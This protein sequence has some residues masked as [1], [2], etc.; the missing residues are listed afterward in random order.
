MSSSITTIVV[1]LLVLSSRMLRIFKLRIWFVLKYFWA[2]EILC[3]CWNI[4]QYKCYNCVMHHYSTTTP[5]LFVVLL[6]H[7]SQMFLSNI[8]ADFHFVRSCE[9]VGGV[10]GHMW[11]DRRWDTMTVD[12]VSRG[13]SSPPAGLCQA[14]RT[15]TCRWGPG[16]T[17]SDRVNPPPGASGIL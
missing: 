10:R 17:G 12:G 15:K 3:C 5:V 11:S 4:W 1:L 14:H 16:Q 9:S 8:H 13:L 7:V 2:V 6:T